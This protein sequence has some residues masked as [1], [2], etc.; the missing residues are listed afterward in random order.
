VSLPFDP[1]GVRILV[2]VTVRGPLRT[3]T[4]GFALDTGSNRTTLRPQLMRML[5]FDLAAPIQVDRFRSVTGSG[6]AGAFVAPIISAL[7]VTHTD[8][9]LYAQ[10]LSAGLT[11]DGL[12]GLD[13][14]RGR[15]V[16]LDFVRGQIT[17]GPPRR[18]WA[19]WR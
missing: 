14:L 2:P 17:L 9:V 6:R 16:T 8:F 11:I 5:G 15:T 4:F 7:G 13:F 1:T 3:H 10:E 12:L 18:W 19:F